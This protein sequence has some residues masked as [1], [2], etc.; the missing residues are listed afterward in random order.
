MD[1]GGGDGVAGSHQRRYQSERSQQIWECPCFLVLA[2]PLVVL[3]CSTPWRFAG[4]RRLSFPFR[5]CA[6]CA[7]G[8][9]FPRPALSERVHERERTA[10]AFRWDAQEDSVNRERSP[11]VTI[12]DAFTCKEVVELVTDYLEN[13]LLPGSP[14]QLEGHVAD[15]PG[16]T[17]Y[18][19]QVRLTVAMLYQLAQEPVFPETKQELLEAF[20]NWKQGSSPQE[21]D[22]H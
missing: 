22:T 8:Q 20:R 16:C 1:P 15:C 10:Y 12:D 3:G 21:A 17:N 19:E 14:K 2:L 7:D 13:A 18:I 11:N 9:A 4:R 5:W 6:R